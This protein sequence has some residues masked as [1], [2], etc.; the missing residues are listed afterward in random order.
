MFNNVEREEAALTVPHPRNK[1]SSQT[2]ALESGSNIVPREMAK[3]HADLDTP[4]V[5][6]NIYRVQVVL[7]KHFLKAFASWVRLL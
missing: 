2:A 4:E 3:L 7:V 6:I 5:G 1:R